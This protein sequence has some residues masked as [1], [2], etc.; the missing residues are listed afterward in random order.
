MKGEATA[1]ERPANSLL[2]SDLDF[3]RSRKP[4]PVITQE[5][6]DDLEEMIKKRVK[7]GDFDD[8]P[9][10]LPDSIP[11]YRPSKFSDVQET[12]SKSLLASSMKKIT[13][14]KTTLMHMRLS[15]MNNLMALIRK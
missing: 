14:S 3:E 15:K 2:E 8:L 9:R 10:R 1:K 6:I 12:K 11:N 5:V 7:K 13:S 4:A